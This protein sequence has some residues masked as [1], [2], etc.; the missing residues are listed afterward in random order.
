MN[1]KLEKSSKAIT[2]AFSLGSSTGFL[3]LKSMIFNDRKIPD[4]NIIIHIKTLLP[5]GDD[6][7]EANASDGASYNDLNTLNTTLVPHSRKMLKLSP[8]FNEIKNRQTQTYTLSQIG[9]TCVFGMHQLT[10]KTNRGM[11]LI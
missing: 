4:A 7:V 5:T 9:L 10:R 2:T 8:V 11:A 6:P 3:K 1:K